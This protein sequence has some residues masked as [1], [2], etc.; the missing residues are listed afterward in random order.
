MNRRNGLRRPT[1]SDRH[2]PVRIVLVDD[3]AHYRTLLRM[4]IADDPRFEVVGEADDGAEGIS[5]ALQLKPD[6]VVLD[7][8]MPKMDGF[9]AIS[10]IRGVSP[11]TRV[12]VC[13]AFHD[14][15]PD[16]VMLGADDYIA[17]QATP[18]E[19]CSR[20]WDLMSRAPIKPLAPQTEWVSPFLLW[21]VL[22][23]AAT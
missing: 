3:D 10:G 22:D 11:E 17:K 14:M 9:Q 8:W 1:R 20:L 4:I 23:R 19:F 16:A 5:R 2:S 21:G 12:L 18:Q 13:T 7:L 6:I 15:G